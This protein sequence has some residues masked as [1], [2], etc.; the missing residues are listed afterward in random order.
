MV[1]QFS[2]MAHAAVC[3]PIPGN[4]TIGVF[5]EDVTSDGRP[6]LWKNRDVIIFNQRF[7]YVQ[8]YQRDSI[9]TIPYIGN[10][11]SS[12]SSRVYMGANSEGFAVVNSDSYNLNDTLTEG[13]DDGTLMRIALEICESID[14]FEVLLD[15]TNDIG[16]KN[17]WNFGVMDGSGACA[18]YECANQS[19]RKFVPDVNE[20]H[21][22]G[23]IIRANFSL[24]GGSPQMGLDRYKRAI[25]L[26]ED[27]LVHEFIDEQYILSKI[28]RDLAN[29]YDDPYP[30]PYYRSQA[31]GPEGYIFNYLCTISNNRTS[32]AAVIKGIRP[33]ENPLLTTVYAVI[34]SPDLSLAYPLWVGSETVPIYL[35]M[36]DSTPMYNYCL[37]RSPRL[38]DNPNAL[39]YIN[40]KALWDELGYGF[41]SYTVPL[42][43]WGIETAN[44]LMEDWRINLP[45]AYEIAMEQ[46]S[47]AMALFAGFQ[48]ENANNV[49]LAGESIAEIPENFKLT[50]YP[51]PF[52]GATVISCDIPGDP[53]PFVIDIYDSLGRLVKSFTGTG[54]AMN[55]VIWN[56]DDSDGDRV[57]SGVYFYSLR[58]GS[59]NLKN[60]MVLLK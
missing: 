58:A 46:F 38:Y 15:S 2:H 42:E 43:N 5:S 49:T 45:P 26:T 40:T 39:F 44:S 37:N 50:N 16:R 10:V 18:L 6:I 51:N 25:H 33:G 30:L 22:N 59:I 1:F 34:G 28:M 23:Y 31:G 7:I 11:N 13:I 35:S 57:K 53:G 17:C 4:C 19:Y 48:Q 54:F 52:N 29:P 3:E 41:Y 21:G 60:K 27:R 9:I 14:D 47:I 24:T 36:P 55:S 32:S 12:D 20:L 56:G 8:S